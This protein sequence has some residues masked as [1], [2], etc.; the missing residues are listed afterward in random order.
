MKTPP[1][2]DGKFDRA[3]FVAILE[4]NDHIFVLGCFFLQTNLDFK[5]SHC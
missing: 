3:I 2:R 5:A 1:R 4:E